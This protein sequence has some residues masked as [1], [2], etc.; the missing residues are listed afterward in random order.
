MTAQSLEMKDSRRWL[1]TALVLASTLATLLIMSGA[2]IYTF[3]SAAA[4]LRFFDPRRPPTFE[5]AWIVSTMD[6]ALA[7]ADKNDII[8]LGDSEC[9]TAVDPVRFESL[10]HL[11]GFNLGIVGDLGPD[12]RLDLMH[13]YLSAHPRPQLAVLCVS[14]VGMERDVPA[15]W[16]L[17]RDRCVQCYG[18]SEPGPWLDDK[19]RYAMRQGAVV[20]WEKVASSI[21]R[22][23]LD[24]RDTPLLGAETETYRAFDSKTRSARGYMPLWG[25]KYET[26]LHHEG[27]VVSID[28]AWDVGVRRLAALC[29]QAGISLMIRLAPIPA[30]GSQS[31]NFERVERWL[32]ELKHSC[33]NVIVADHPTFLRYS[34]DFFWDP[35]HPN[36]EGAAKFTGTLAEEV[37][38]AIAKQVHVPSSDVDAQRRDNDR[39]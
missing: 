34:A 17:L 33:P 1:G 6:Y 7:S 12:V 9:R 39:R 19:R 38:A 20:A 26:R 16:K 13:A 23:R 5:E 31:L 21:E 15:Q 11:R 27:E 2:S 25:N 14:P 22:T 37:R 32:A 10:T 3:G 30:D 28:P 8:F 24:I 18:Q 35:T 4:N 29:K 36:N